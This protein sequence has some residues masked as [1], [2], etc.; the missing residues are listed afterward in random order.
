MEEVGLQEWTQAVVAMGLTNT[1]PAAAS[2]TLGGKAQIAQ[3]LP[4]L[5]SAMTTAD[6]WMESVCAIR[7]T[8]ER[9]AAS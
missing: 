4:A 1:T 8:Q 9:T 5:T 7:A 3:C 6:V 2:V